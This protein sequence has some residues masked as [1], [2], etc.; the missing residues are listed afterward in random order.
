MTEVTSFR[1]HEC[2]NEELAGIALLSPVMFCLID[3]QNPMRAP[4]STG[5]HA[6]LM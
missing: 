3:G 4:P 6:P 2:H 1:R 5:M